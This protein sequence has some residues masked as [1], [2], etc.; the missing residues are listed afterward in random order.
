MGKSV[1]TAV[2]APLATV[3][4]LVACFPE[5][6]GSDF[7]ATSTLHKTEIVAYSPQD[8]AG[9]NVPEIPAGIQSPVEDVAEEAKGDNG[10]TAL[11]LLAEY[12]Y[13]GDAYAATLELMGDGADPNAKNKQ[14]YAPLH[15]AWASF[16]KYSPRK[17]GIIDIG[18][19]PEIPLIIVAG[20]L[21]TESSYFF[22]QKSLT[23]QI[24][25]PDGFGWK[26]HQPP[27][28]WLHS[29]QSIGRRT[30]MAV[31][32]T[33][34]M[35]LASSHYDDGQELSSLN[36]ELEA[37]DDFRTDIFHAARIMF[38]D[39]RHDIISALLE[40][41][42][43]PNL[44]AD[45]GTTPLDWAVKYKDYGSDNSIDILREKG[46]KLGYDHCP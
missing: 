42:A 6:E 16:D 34:A 38:I 31:L 21:T 7:L 26:Y 14:G 30:P 27:K 43:N 35:M 9:P 22:S 10:L 11:H 29:I 33:V 5:A 44:C 17:A 45:D 46:A 2:I 37:R 20:G 19:G 28:P 25:I 39:T 12:P 23:R 15:W 8:G 1:F 40:A 4:A 36:S 13:Y 41:G 3:I 24:V 32:A 18:I